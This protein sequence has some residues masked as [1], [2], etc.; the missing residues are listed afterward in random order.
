M[1]GKDRPAHQQYDYAEQGALRE[2]VVEEYPQ[3]GQM[4]AVITRNIYGALVLN[5]ADLLIADID[6]PVES[7]SS[8]VSRWWNQL[9]GRK[10]ESPEAKIIDTV[11]RVASEQRLSLRLYRTHAGFRCLVTSRSFLPTSDEAKALLEQLNTDPLYM[12]LCNA[13]EC[14]RARLSPK[15]WRCNLPRPPFR[16]PYGSAAAVS[17]Q[18]KWE[19]KY[20]AAVSGYSTCQLIQSA[21]DGRVMEGLRFLVDL[22][23]QL[24]CAGDG[25]L[26]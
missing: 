8:T 12:K 11:L 2:E 5:T 9:W 4:K 7:A 19:E 13:Q 23:D 18:R 26:A 20:A 6:L 1:S 22:H 15:P 21:G 17:E 24:A 25:P 14:F 3:D 16:F 10:V